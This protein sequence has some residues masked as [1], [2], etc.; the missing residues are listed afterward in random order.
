MNCQAVQNQILGLPEPRELPP[1]L[2]EHVLSCPE[3]RAWARQAAR[4]EV[5]L[6]RLPTPPAPG[7]KKEV[8]LG[9][10]MAVEPVIRPMAVLATR[11]G[12][13]VLAVRF[14]Q[15]NAMYVG[16][17]AAAVLLAVGVYELR[18]TKT[19]VAV[20]DGPKAKDPLVERLVKRN[21][22]LA[23]AET[24]AKKLEVLNGMADDIVTDARGVANLAPGADLQKMAGR[25]ETVV[26]S[27]MVPRAKELK[28]QPL[29]MAP[30]E[31]TKLLESLA[32]K[33][34]ADAAATEKLAGE[35]KQD[36]QPALKRMADAAREGEKLL[37]DYA[38]EDK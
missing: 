7:E 34:G 37:R 17:L 10:L 26:K 32:A 1:A 33:L 24:T 15:R 20:D 23:R 3:C 18:P 19:T 38:R 21:V 36:A 25:Y 27:G 9:D 31:K 6:E 12:P 4:L 35:A 14:L 8:L 28:G 30:G 2:R 13:G 29:A 5:L 16:G 11:P 22:A